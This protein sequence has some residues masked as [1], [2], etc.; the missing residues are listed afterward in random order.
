MHQLAEPAMLGQQVP[1]AGVLAIA[2]LQRYSSCLTRRQRSA[3]VA[4]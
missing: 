4:T 3:A 2:V 1:C